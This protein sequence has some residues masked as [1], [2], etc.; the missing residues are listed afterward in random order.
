MRLEGFGRSKERRR[1][2]RIKGSGKMRGDRECGE[3]GDGGCSSDLGGIIRWFSGILAS[4]L[5]RGPSL[6]SWT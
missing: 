6:L 2:S 3:G 4:A 5:E 1:G